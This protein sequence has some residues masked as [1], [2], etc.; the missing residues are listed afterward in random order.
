MA[1][2]RFD[3]YYKVL[4]KMNEKNATEMLCDL[5]LVI[6]VYPFLLFQAPCYAMPSDRPDACYQS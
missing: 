2:E 4:P 5:F 1:C 6:F 3:P